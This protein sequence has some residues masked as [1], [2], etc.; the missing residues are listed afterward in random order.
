M[1]KNSENLRQDKGIIS[2]IVEQ[3]LTFDISIKFVRGVKNVSPNF[4]RIA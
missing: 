1:I 4:K 2:L 3:I